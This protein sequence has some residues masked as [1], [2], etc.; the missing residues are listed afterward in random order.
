MFT[1]VTCPVPLPFFS[2]TLFVSSTGSVLVSAAQLFVFKRLPS[3]RDDTIPVHQISLLNCLSLAITGESGI[4]LSE[5]ERERERG[6]WHQREKEI[7]ADSNTSEL[8]C[9]VL[10]I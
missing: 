9:C 2:L 3:S 8:L 6:T 7:Q 4:Y 5:I 1:P 10:P